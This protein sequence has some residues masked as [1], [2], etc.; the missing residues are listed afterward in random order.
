MR[1]TDFSRAPQQ[2]RAEAMLVAEAGTGPG[3]TDRGG[4]ARHARRH[5]TAWVRRA[6]RTVRADSSVL[7]A[8]P[9]QV[10]RSGR[11]QGVI[12]YLATPADAYRLGAT[13]AADVPAPGAV[14]VRTRV[15]LAEESGY[16]NGVWRAE[17]QTMAHIERFTPVTREVERGVEPPRVAD[18]RPAGRGRGRD[19]RRRGARETGRETRSVSAAPGEGAPAQEAG[20]RA[21]RAR[22]TS[23]SPVDAHAMFIGA[24]RYRGLHS[25]VVLARDWYPMVATMQRLRG[26]VWHTIY[27]E[28]P[29]TLGTLAF[30]DTRD[31]LLVFA[32]VPAH[33]RLMQWIT[34]GTRNGTGGYIRLHV[35]PEA[36]GAA[37]GDD[38]LGAHHPVDDPEAHGLTDERPGGGPA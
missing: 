19:G 21:P 6:V 5:A 10:D 20:A 14:S 15:L 18:P 23:G 30:F 25:W 9:Y 17:D 24:T 31:D 11:A 2:A 1:T 38:R 16:T 27:W 3:R 28:P 35:D 37:D 13:L 7:W 12:V 4:Q 34:R 36:G 22:R 32:R 26:Y 33:R 8:T 29:F